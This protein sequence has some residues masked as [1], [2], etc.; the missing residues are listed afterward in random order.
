MPL[1][2][3]R[4]PVEGPAKVCDNVTSVSFPA[5]AG[6]KFAQEYQYG[7]KDWRE[8]YGHGRNSVESFN[9]CLKDGGRDC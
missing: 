7:S 8:M 3:I 1:T 4:R 9:A 6:G 2:I 5:E